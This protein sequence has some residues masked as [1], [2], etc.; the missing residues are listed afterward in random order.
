[1]QQNGGI[2]SNTTGMPL[3]TNRSS[4]VDQAKRQSTA[5]EAFLNRFPRTFAI[6]CHH[7]PSLAI[8]C[9]HLPSLAIT[10]PPSFCANAGALTGCTLVEAVFGTVQSLLLVASTAKF[11]ED[12]QFQICHR[13]KSQNVSIIS[14]LQKIA[15]QNTFVLGQ[16]CCP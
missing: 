9:H 10:C 14:V 2:G 11:K 12:W 8:T 6:T 5:Q 3:D 7:L 15:H 13:R 4:I 1:M 16:K